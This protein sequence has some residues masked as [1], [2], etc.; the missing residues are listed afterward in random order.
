M[1][2][3]V[4]NHTFIA[5]SDEVGYDL[6]KTGRFLVQFSNG[7]DLYIDMNLG[8]EVTQFRIKDALYARH[9][10]VVASLNVVAF[11]QVK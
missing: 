9:G 3:A 10:S 5:N 8:V 7:D 4:D 2:D 6:V 11:W 1:F